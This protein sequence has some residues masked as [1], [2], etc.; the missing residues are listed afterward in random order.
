ME[1]LSVHVLCGNCLPILITMVSLG[2][3]PEKST[4]VQPIMHCLA[5]LNFN[6]MTEAL[7]SDIA[8]LAGCILSVPHHYLYVSDSSVRACLQHLFQHLEVSSLVRKELILQCSTSFLGV[9]YLKNT[10]ACCIEERDQDNCTEVLRHALLELDNE[11]EKYT[12][13]EEKLQT[14]QEKMSESMEHCVLVLQALQRSKNTFHR[15]LLDYVQQHHDAYPI[16]HKLV[17]YGTCNAGINLQTTSNNIVA[18]S[19][20]DEMWITFALSYYK[21]QV[22]KSDE[23]S[24]SKKKTFQVCSF[25]RDV[26]ELKCIGFSFIFVHLAQ[27]GVEAVQQLDGPLFETA[28]ERHGE[29]NKVY[30]RRIVSLIECIVDMEFPLVGNTV[31]SYWSKLFHAVYLYVLGVQCVQNGKR[32]HKFLGLTLVESFFLVYPFMGE[33]CRVRWCWFK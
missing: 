3:C 15:G 28:L 23:V 17:T 19:T 22:A 21:N 30:L 18:C 13:V 9:Q 25:L 29:K 12:T 14:I 5:S 31:F 10:S 27:G 4:F 32:V 24:W 26:M 2:P 20:E 7:V 6:G 11:L 8:R 1:E 33:C 16:L